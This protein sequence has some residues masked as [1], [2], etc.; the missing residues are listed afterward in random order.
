MRR[1]EFSLDV[2]NIDWVEDEDADAA[3]PTVTITFTG[4]AALEDRLL[5]PDGDLLEADEIDVALRLQGDVDDPETTGVVAVTDRLTGDF[6]LELNQDAADVLKFIRAAREYGR[7]SDADKRY[8]VH[9]ERGDNHV[10]TYE[11]DTFLVYNTEGD[12][13]RRHSLIPS[14]IEI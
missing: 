3:L 10:V 12:L 8:R 14:G 9:I 5:A 13:L 6:V 11:K 7:A 4:D 1:Q 2:T